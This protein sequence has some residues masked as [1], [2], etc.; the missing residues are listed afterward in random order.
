MSDVS[1]PGPFLC[2]LNQDNE[3]FARKPTNISDGVN[4]DYLRALLASL[5][6]LGLD[7]PLDRLLSDFLH[8]G[9]D[10]SSTVNGATE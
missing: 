8:L 4:A 2:Q 5:H 9:G 6:S 10:M 1:L 7:E 3:G